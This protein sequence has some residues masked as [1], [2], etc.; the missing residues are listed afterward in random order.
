M[1]A[2]KSSIEAN[3]HKPTYENIKNM[4][5]LLNESFVDVSVMDGDTDHVTGAKK[6]ASIE[7][8]PTSP[9]DDVTST[10][11]DEQASA[12]TPKETTDTTREER[13]EAV[14]LATE[15]N[16]ILEFQLNK[17]LDDHDK[18]PMIFYLQST[19]DSG[20][21]DLK[22]E[23][24]KFCPENNV[25]TVEY[26]S[27]ETKSRLLKKGFLEF[28]NKYKLF[29][30]S[31]IDREK[32]FTLD[33]KV[34]ILANVDEN[35]PI[36]DVRVMANFYARSEQG[37]NPAGTPVNSSFFKDTFYIRFENEL[38]LETVEQRIAKLPTMHDREVKLVK[39]YK[40]NMVL[41]RDPDCLQLKTKIDSIEAFLKTLASSG[42]HGKAFQ[43]VTLRLMEPYL[44]IRCAPDSDLT[45]LAP[46]F[47]SDIVIEGRKYLVEYLHNLDM[48]ENDIEDI[49]TRPVPLVA[50]GMSGTPVPK[51][52][53]SGAEPLREPISEGRVFYRNY[54]KNLPQETTNFTWELNEI[55]QENTSD[56]EKFDD[57]RVVKVTINIPINSA[58]CARI[59]AIEFKDRIA[60]ELS[61]SDLI[62][63]DK[64][65]EM[66][67]PACNVNQALNDMKN[68]LRTL[69][70]QN[71]GTQ[72]NGGIDFNNFF[73][74]KKLSVSK[75]LKEE[76][77][78]AVIMPS[79]TTP[80]L[81]IWSF[82]S[83]DVIE[84]CIKFIQEKVKL[85]EFS[86]A[87][88]KLE[89]FKQFM[90]TVKNSPD[91]VISEPVEGQKLFK[92]AGMN[93]AVD[94]TLREITSNF[95]N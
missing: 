4:T 89:E 45:A 76:G 51:T 38:N 19:V 9:A 61:L 10:R 24:F 66:T 81:R 85:V 58:H 71:M 91:F 80:A 50:S 53:G 52:P 72:S 56:D 68:E 92:I 82:N 65:F 12:T 35:E 20:G 49:K 88:S 79:V 63:K 27:A 83:D 75:K 48:L 43:F 13:S 25:I 23:S 14:S 90:E 57:K 87:G 59:L 3:L 11:K 33:E 86:V 93:N 73:A 8:T 18:D 28:K 44:I 77:I 67:G 39:A 69:K 26:D 32:D 16:R 30:N 7:S 74:K 47:A 22:R 34:M 5:V 41:L 42:D 21:D 54:F 6:E 46:I 1:K 29:V 15:E 37:T 36:E 62:L 2:V 70:F 31:P 84:K 55:L 95:T 78:T 94:Q 64:T 17:F 40:S 60:K